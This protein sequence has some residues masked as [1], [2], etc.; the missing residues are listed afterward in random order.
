VEAPTDEHIL[1]LYT[2]TPLWSAKD[3]LV[4]K[5]RLINRGSS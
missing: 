5:A 2:C 4:I 3:R 1:T